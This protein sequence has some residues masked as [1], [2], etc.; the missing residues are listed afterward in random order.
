MQTARFTKRDRLLKKAEFDL[1][2]KQGRRFSAGSF[3]AMVAP[4]EHGHAR[5]GFALAKKNAP[6]AVQ[7]NRIRRLLRER[8]RL[9]QAALGT[10]DL[11]ISLRGKPPSGASELTAAVQDFWQQL[12]RRCARS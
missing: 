7:R 4:N 2:F 5:L 3:L 11:V 8:F 12:A 6:L 9:G 10:V 1:A